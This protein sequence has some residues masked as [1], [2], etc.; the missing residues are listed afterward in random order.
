M[1]VNDNKNGTCT[2]D[3]RDS[4]GKRHRKLIKGSKTFAKEVLHKIQ[5]EISE[6]TYFPERVKQKITFRQAAEK[7]WELHGS[8]TRSA[9]KLKYTFDKIVEYF[10]DRPLVNISVEDMQ[11]YYNM[12][13]DRTSGS[14]AN[15]Y[16]TTVR[17]I[18]N[19][20]TKLRLYTNLSP[21][22]GVIR[23]PENPM[24]TEFLSKEAI[25]AIVKA[26]SERYRP[27][28]ICAITTG[29]RRGEI[30][31]LDWRDVDLN[32]NKIHIHI[33]KSGKSREV[34]LSEDARKLF[35][36][37]EP[38]LEG[39]VFFLTEAMIR[40][41]H[42]NAMR[43][44]NLPHMPLHTLRHTFA[45]QFRINNGNLND[46]QDFLG[47]STMAL[48]KRYAH[49]NTEYINQAIQCI[50][51]LIPAVEIKPLTA[52]SVRMRSLSKK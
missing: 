41:D 18:I 28:L 27:F 33:A 39:K 47:H 31:N 52:D 13:L 36:S 10:G 6:G 35:L 12:V 46:L 42:K 48:T 43:D 34:P 29:L 50:N 30:M 45:T 8:K 37:L 2:I 14:T 1:A 4:E 5:T 7:Y 21:C 9:K 23:K 19:L 20:M 38:K 25:V 16:F 32:T 24:R 44:A 51:G 22:V 40:L 11:I 49:L 15:R 26:A 17:A 3:Y